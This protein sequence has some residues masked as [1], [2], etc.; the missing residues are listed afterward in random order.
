MP[1]TDRIP[2]SSVLTF[3]LH[4]VDEPDDILFTASRLA[5]VGIRA[6]F[7]VPSELLASRDHLRALR[8][9]ADHGHDLG[10]HGHL[11]DWREIQ[12]LMGG[13][14]GELAFLSHSHALHAQH[15]G[16]PPRSFRSPRWCRLGQAAVRTLERLGY[17]VDSS[18]TPQRLPWLSSTPFHAGWLWTNR[19]PHLLGRSLLELPT[20][21]FGVPF[22]APA[23]ATLRRSLSLGMLDLLEWEARNSSERAIVTMMHVEDLNPDTRRR[24][25]PGRFVARD[26]LPRAQGGFRAKLFLRERD[27]RRIAALHESLLDRLAKLPQVTASE[28]ASGW[29][30]RRAAIPRA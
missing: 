27:P 10:S 20:S 24:L 7:F 16:T 19:A 22:S 13:D 14:L 5:S 3:D 11:H 23:F 8:E 30:S 29:R 26:L 25:D 4:S 1:L 28:F 18:A 17:D 15:L 2:P 6:T 12:A 21:C 9:L